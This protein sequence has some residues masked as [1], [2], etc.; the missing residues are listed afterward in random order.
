MIDEAQNAF[1][2]YNKLL[3][4]ANRFS[5]SQIIKL[6]EDQA[7]RISIASYNMKDSEPY[8]G[9]GSLVNFIMDYMK[10]LKQVRDSFHSYI[11]LES[12]LTCAI[13][14]DIGRIGID[15]EDRLI[16]QDSDWHREKLG[17]IYKWN[18]AC[19]KMYVPHASLYWINKYD[20]KLSHEELLA[21]LLTQDYMSEE[22]KFYIGSEPELVLCL[23]TARNIVMT[24]AKR[25]KN[26]M[27]NPHIDVQEF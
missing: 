14:S 11:D 22:A 20:I 19:P 4:L 26:I 16:P 10:K 12:A 13:I 5:D 2:N 27:Q 6:L 8:C 1:D 15:N 18:E 25:Y 21:I 24:D 9:T 23:R 3:N 17:Q 7:E